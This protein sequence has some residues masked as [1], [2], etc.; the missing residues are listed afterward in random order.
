M[1]D[2]LETAPHCET[3]CSTHHNNAVLH[4]GKALADDQL[5]RLL[6]QL[7]GRPC[8]SS[9]AM[10]MTSLFHSCTGDRCW[11]QPWVALACSCGALSVTGCSSE[12]LAGR[13]SS[14]S[15]KQTA[16]SRLC[17]VAFAG[18][19]AV[20]ASLRRRF[21][22]PA[23]VDLRQV[24]PQL[25]QCAGFWS[26]AQPTC[27]AHAAV[28]R[29]PPASHSQQTSSS[30]AAGD[31]A[32]RLSE[33]AA[34]V[35]RLA[36][37][38]AGAAAPGAQPQPQQLACLTVT[39]RAVGALRKALPEGAMAAALPPEA[40]GAASAALQTAGCLLAAAMRLES[41]ADTHSCNHA[42]GELL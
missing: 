24:R 15:V 21:R 11:A 34:S 39:L 25:T 10:D 17:L 36:E 29:Q 26:S 42:A 22:T 2:I 35:R 23:A 1:S 6:E 14:Q 7:A 18:W 32:Q 19:Q 31:W 40:A 3:V 16:V 4:A 13:H 27:G 8:S 28:Q 12:S 33:A 38:P 30:A 5:L 41:G 9:E 37:S 20:L